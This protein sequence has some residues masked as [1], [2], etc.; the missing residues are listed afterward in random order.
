MQVLLSDAFLQPK[1]PI[2]HYED[3]C[4]YNRPKPVPVLKAQ[5]HKGFGTAWPKHKKY[6][7]EVV[8]KDKSY[9]C[10]P[11][12]VT[13]MQSEGT[14]RIIF[15]GGQIKMSLIRNRSPKQ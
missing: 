1:V 13:H 7:A 3:H 11:Y 10:Y 15:L 8:K 14:L 6:H 2:S 5:N 9:E 4:I 12:M